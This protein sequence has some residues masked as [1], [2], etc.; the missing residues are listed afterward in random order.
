MNRSA[1]VRAWA[2]RPRWA[3]ASMRNTVTSGRKV[4]AR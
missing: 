4:P 3:S 2:V 1:S